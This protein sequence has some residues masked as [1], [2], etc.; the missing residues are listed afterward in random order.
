MVL[1]PEPRPCVSS[2]LKPPKY[3]VSHWKITLKG[4]KFQKFRLRRAQ[5]GIFTSSRPPQAE[6]FENPGPNKRCCRQ[7][8]TK[9]E[10]ND[11]PARR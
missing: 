9:N 11:G 4:A 8:T 1:E 5:Q 7:N 3:P 10:R 6:I 2:A